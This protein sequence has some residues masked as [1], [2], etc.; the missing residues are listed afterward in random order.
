[1]AA[2]SKA[3]ATFRILGQ[4]PVVWGE[5]NEEILYESIFL[6]S[7]FGTRARVY[8]CVLGMAVFSRCRCLLCIIIIMILFYLEACCVCTLACDSLWQEC[9]HTRAR[10]L[11]IKAEGGRWEREKMNIF[12]S[13]HRAAPT[14]TATTPSP[15]PQTALSAFKFKYTPERW[16]S[17]FKP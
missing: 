4:V 3:V 15:P 1:M 11:K 10:S 17:C 8:V 12:V 14:V 16:L 6:R 2:F 7:F 9:T 13:A 5:L